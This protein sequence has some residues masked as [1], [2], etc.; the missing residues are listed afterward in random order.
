MNKI[1][2]YIFVICIIILFFGVA[3]IPISSIN[4]ELNTQKKLSFVNVEIAEKVTNQKIYELGKASEYTIEKLPQVIRTDDNAISCYLFK[5][6]PAGYMII[7]AYYEL[8]P[9]IAYSFLSVIDLPLSDD[10]RFYQMLRQDMNLRFNA[11]C[12][13]PENIIEER[14]VKW[15]KLIGEYTVNFPENKFQQWPP[16]G[17]TPTGGWVETNWHQNSPFNDFCP[18]DFNSGEK[19][20]AGC[21]AVTMAQILNY[22]KTIN[23]VLFTDDDDYY[24]NYGGNQYWI[25]DDYEA[26]DFPSYPVLNNYLDELI[27][28][29][30]NQIPLTSDDKA[31]L[32]F[33]CG[34]AANQVYNPS[35]SGTFGVNQAYDAYIKFN[36]STIELVDESNPDMYTRLAG[37]M[38]NA[39]PAHL[40]VVNP[41]W[42]AGHNLVVDG[43]N[44]NDYFHLNFGWNG[45]YD[46]WYLLPDEIPYSLTVI[47]GVILD[48]FP[49][50]FQIHITNITNNWNFISIP[51]NETIE[52]T[53]I[54]IKYDNIEYTWNEAIDPV[55][56]PIIDPNVYGWDRNLDMYNPV[57]LLDSG[58]GYWIYSY[59]DCELWI[60]NIYVFSD[61]SITEL[62]QT[63]NIIGIPD[64]ESINK[65]DLIVNYL[66]TD[67]TWSEAINPVNG[68]IVDP[69]VYSW[70]RINGM[71]VPAGD[72]L[73]PGHAYWM[74]AYEDCILKRS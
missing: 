10:D 14:T 22:H 66:G 44:T 69:N 57:S 11:L 12:D 34:V 5:L 31:S 43:Y 50:K 54:I 21:P 15:K 60:E 8:P 62:V 6:Q 33:A 24:H 65:T 27:D 2:K 64:V 41:D 16:D 17:T 45:A 35:G 30:E 40:A 18:I 56:G 9:V 59:V 42:T 48:I 51:F 37:N 52:L 19:S 53:D 47:E 28:H 74:Y 29:Y 49:E 23:G 67:Y 1:K 13:L 72:N 71:Y 25:D 73:Y 63:W 4:E 26:Y 55:N 38:K 3:I 20:L 46:G 36:F 58:Y 39:T 32:T 61:Y 7:T 68:P 70:D